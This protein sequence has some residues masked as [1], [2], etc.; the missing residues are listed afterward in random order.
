MI[1]AIQ[2]EHV[3]RTTA[4]SLARYNL[5]TLVHSQVEIFG[6]GEVQRRQVVSSFYFLN[7]SET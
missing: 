5:T 4:A 7:V 2:A 3:L 1:A 6:C